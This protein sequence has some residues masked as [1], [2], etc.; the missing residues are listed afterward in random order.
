MSPSAGAAVEITNLTKRFGSFV[1]VDD[2][3]FTVEPGRITGFLGP[4][5]AGKTTSLRM[6]LDLVSPTSG[7]ATI[8]GKR[9]RDLERPMTVVGAALEATNFHPGR[10]GRDHLR[11]L[12]TSNGIPAT[13]VDEL[14]ELTGIPAAARKRAGEYSMG[15]RQRLGLAAAL[16]GDPRVLIL[17]EP[18]NGLDPEGIRWLRGFLRHLSG[19]GKTI[20]VSSHLLQ[21]VQQT[22]DEVVI[23]N[24]GR[25]LR[26]GTMAELSGGA[27]TVVRTSDTD[28]L[29]GALLLADVVSRPGPDGVLLAETTDMRLVG[30]VA[31]RAGL[32]VWELK[33]KQADLEELFF[34][35]TDGTNRNLGG[36]TGDA[37]GQ[38]EAA[39]TERDAVLGQEGGNL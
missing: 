15:M 12:A 1:A 36:T 13:R 5:G 23:I 17:D 29:A 2:L 28:Q 18:S 39:P 38:S 14:L 25:L 16:L 9:Y 4:N 30:D 24:N 21:E 27:A 34:S 26:S 11:V 35:L 7:R 3:S 32:P 8:D 33:A 20:L 10:S 22:V 37:Q 31:L 19:E 6:V